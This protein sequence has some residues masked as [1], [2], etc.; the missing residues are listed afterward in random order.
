LISR[1]KEFSIK[2]ANAASEGLQPDGSMIYEKNHV[3]GR[4]GTER[5]WWV[6]A[7]T[8][9]G[10][11]NAYELTGNENYLDNSLNCWNY[12]KNHMVDNKNG[13]WFSSVSETGEI[14]H[15]DKAGFWICP[16]HD[17]RMCMEIIE[18]LSLH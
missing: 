17:G 9:V 3:T 2:I 7:E 6:Q 10:Y 18:R 15:S 11:M 5:S 8:V 12:I 14:G 16:Y 4:T 13:G 1:V